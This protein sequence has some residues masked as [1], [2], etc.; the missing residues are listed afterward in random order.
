MDRT[1]EQLASHVTGL[2]Y[3]W[4]TPGAVHSAKRL[5]IDAIGCAVGGYHSEPAAI[6]RKLAAQT[7]GTPPARVLG[8]AAI[9]SM[10]AATFANSVMLRYLDFNDTYTSIGEGHPSD[11]IPAVLAVA[12]G[13]HLSGKDTI[14]GLAATYEVYNGL[15]DSVSLRDKGWDHGYFVVFAAAAGAGKL[16]GLT[17]EQ[18]GNAIALASA[19]NVPTRQ[20][21]SGE[22]SMWKGCA[23]AASAR[24]GVFAAQLAK[25][26]MTGPAEAF[27]GRHGVFDQVTGPFTLQPLGAHPRG[28]GL[29]RTGIKFFPTEYHSQIPLGLVLKL[30]GQIAVEDIEVLHVETYNLAYSEIGSEPQKWNPQTRETADHSLPYMLAAAVQD[31]SISVA[32]FD[33]AR[34]R[35]PKLRPLMN[36]IK[37]SENAEFTRDF[38]RFMR[39]R[40]EIVTK[41]GRR[42]VE[43]E[44]YPKGHFENPMTDAEVESKFR[45]LCN[46][47]MPADRCEATLQVVWGLERAQDVGQVLELV[48]IEGQ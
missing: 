18:M 5:L 37:V 10:E 30:R 11:A 34:I 20:T 31:G 24:A 38:P 44:R 21:R 46:G 13:L 3:E 26:G 33:E 39:N 32:T 28:F 16:L 8:S 19:P 35:D 14:L 7:S 43:E 29:E 25:E 1:T 45:A 6:A 2:R 36:R 4:L 9:T 15:A 17:L 47:L 48:R 22:L 40:I 23:T 12:D 42:L 27:E 41:G